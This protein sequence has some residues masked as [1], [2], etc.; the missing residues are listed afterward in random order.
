MSAT[1]EV[2]RIAWTPG[3]DRLRGTCHCGAERT[4]EDP[5][6]MWDWLFAHPSGHRTKEE[7]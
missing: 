4:G 5:A 3:G 2:V 6:E 7:R 1:R